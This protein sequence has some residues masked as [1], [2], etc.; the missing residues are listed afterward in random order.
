MTH[1]QVRLNLHQRV[2]DNTDKN[3]EG[4]STKESGKLPLY[5]KDAS[6]GRKNGDQCQEQ[7]ARECD[8]RHNLID[9]VCSFL[10]R[11][12]SWNETIIS[13]HVFGHLHRIDSD[14]CIQ[15]GKQDNQNSKDEIVHKAII[16][17]QLV[18]QWIQLA[19]RELCQS[20]RDK[21]D[22]LSEDDRHHVCSIGLQWNIL[23]C[24]TNLPST[25][26]FL[27]IIDRNTTHTLHKK[28]CSSN[29]SKEKYDLNKEHDETTLPC[30]QT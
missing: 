29:H 13:L 6:K 10:T 3:E 4:S 27:C 2:K 7:R 16:V 21:H 5:T 28:Y 1:H 12:D 23:T 30:F 18:D 9:I 25:C 15:I 17:Y 11:L 19:T 8:T 20:D 26:N 14:C 22:S 24:T